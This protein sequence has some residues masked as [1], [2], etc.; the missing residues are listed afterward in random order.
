M[1]YLRILGRLY[2][3]V[4]VRECMQWN[5]V[6][7]IRFSKPNPLLGRPTAVTGKVILRDGLIIKIM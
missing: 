1:I 4:I 7:I 2:Q 3:A 6:F 5:V